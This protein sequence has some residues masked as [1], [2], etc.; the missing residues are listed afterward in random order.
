MCRNAI[1]AAAA[2]MVSGTLARCEDVKH[3]SS[4]GRGVVLTPLGRRIFLTDLSFMIAIFCYD[5][6]VE[7]LIINKRR[8]VNY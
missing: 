2:G 8:N 7:K 5:L 6:Q 4:G 3:V 1:M